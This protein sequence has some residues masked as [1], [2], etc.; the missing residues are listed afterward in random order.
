M[1][2]KGKPISKAAGELREAKAGRATG[3]RKN[4]WMMM[5]ASMLADDR[6]KERGGQATRVGR[7]CAPV[8]SH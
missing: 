4:G 3:A 6:S 7:W 8:D 1:I 2:W 5:V